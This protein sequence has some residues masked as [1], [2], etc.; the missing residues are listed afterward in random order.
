[1]FINGVQID[2]PFG[3]LFKVVMSRPTASTFHLVGYVDGVSQRTASIQRIHHI[4]D[5]ATDTSVYIAE[6]RNMLYTL[7]MDTEVFN[8]ISE[9]HPEFFLTTDEGNNP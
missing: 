2:K 7:T 8:I 5:E 1:M 4:V 6:T 3:G 9:R